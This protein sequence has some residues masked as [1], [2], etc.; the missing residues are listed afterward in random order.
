[1]NRLYFIQKILGN[2]C[3][4]FQYYI[5]IQSLIF[6][7]RYPI[8]GNSDY[9]YIVIETHYDN[10]LKEIGFVEKLTLRYYATKN[11]R[12]NEL[13]ILIIGAYLSPV[14]IAIPPKESAFSISSYCYA[15]CTR[16]VGKSNFC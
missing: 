7:K 13:G 10:P 11:L 3:F 12:K 4:F 16:K 2:F 15:D 5:L 9:K 8:G 6:L 14:S 1:M